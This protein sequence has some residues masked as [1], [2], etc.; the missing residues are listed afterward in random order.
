MLDKKLLGLNIREDELNNP[1]NHPETKDVELQ[2]F[3]R[4]QKDH[5]MY[6]DEVAHNLDKLY[7]L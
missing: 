7:D 3:K 1:N 4:V 2:K 5:K 6:K